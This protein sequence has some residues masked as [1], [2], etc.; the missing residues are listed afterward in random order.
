MKLILALKTH[1]NKE[2]PGKVLMLFY[3]EYIRHSVVNITFKHDLTRVYNII[4]MV[5]RNIS[6]I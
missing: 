6:E 5:L 3:F 1:T 4:N 2:Q